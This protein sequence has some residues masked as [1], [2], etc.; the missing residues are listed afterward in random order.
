M[1]LMKVALVE[2]HNGVALAVGD[3]Q[4][5][6]LLVGDDVVLVSTR[7]AR[8]LARIAGILP[9]YPGDRQFDRG[10]VGYRVKVIL[11]RR[12][13]GFPHQEIDALEEPATA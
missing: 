13:P 2:E 11:R 7:G 1:R 12:D 5:R 6:E 4:G 8:E 3:V 10:P 9:D